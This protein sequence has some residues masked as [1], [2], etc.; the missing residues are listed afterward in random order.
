MNATIDQPQWSRQVVNTL[1]RT[2][3][4]T[5]EQGPRPWLWLSGAHSE[6]L[7]EEVQAITNGFDYRWVWSNTAWEYGSPGYRQGPLLVPLNESVYVHALDHW[8]TQQAG[9]ILLGPDDG[10]NLV[11]HLQRLRQLTASDGFPLGFSLNAARQ[12][13]ELCEALPSECLSEL[14]GPIQRFIWYAGDERT[15]EWLFADSPSTDHPASVTNEPIALSLDD[16]AAL[17]RASLAWFMRDCAREFRQRFPAYGHPENEPALWRHLNHF[18][19]EAT[20]QLAL[21]TERDVRHYMELRFQYPHD[22]FAMD[23]TLRDI[24]LQRQVKGKQRLFDA[25]ARLVAR[26]AATS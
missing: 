26:A 17:D 6:T 25:E 20:D 3:W 18:A 22:F 1:P 5:L 2:R 8:L 24:L 15:G 13:E 23:A 14:F 19:N 11:L 12:L 9:L 21:T 7:E 16:E 10:D 4:A